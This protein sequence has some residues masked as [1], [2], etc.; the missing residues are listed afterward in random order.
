MDRRM[1]R[2]GS[3][4]IMLFALLK[5]RT[6]AHDLCIFTD[7]LADGLWWIEMD[8]VVRAAEKSHGRPRLV[9]FYRWHIAVGT[10]IN[11]GA[12]FVS[13]IRYT[14]TNPKTQKIMAGPFFLSRFSLCQQ[15]T[16]DE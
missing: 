2:D 8:R 11:V 7:G 12:N 14:E 10:F 15:P 5:N 13:S 1:D 3:R 6:G 16:D 4:W 9:H